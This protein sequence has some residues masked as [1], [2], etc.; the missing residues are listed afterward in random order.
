MDEHA[1]FSP[2]GLHLVLKCPGSIRLAEALALQGLDVKKEPSEAA[3]HGSL[4]HTYVPAGWKNPAVLKELELNDR[5]YV[6]ECIEYLQTLIKSLGHNN[7]HLRFEERVSLKHWGLSEVWGT[8][9]VILID[10]AARVLH[11]IDWKFGSGVPVYAYNNPQL[12]AYAGGALS[13]AYAKEIEVHVVQPPLDSATTERLSYFEL[14]EWVHGTLAIGIGKC[15]SEEPVFVP[16]EEQC[17]FCPVK[18]HCDTRFTWAQN[19]AE[20]LFKA[21]DLLPTKVTPDAIME[22]LKRAPLV[23]KVIKDL[24]IFIFNELQQGSD[25]YPDYKLVRG[26]SI[27]KWKNEADVLA[28]LD[29][30]DEDDIFITKLISPAQAEKLNKAFKKDEKFHELYEKPEGKLSLAPST[31]YREAV[32]PERKAVDIF[33]DYAV[34]DSLE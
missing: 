1:F 7:Y 24:R 33:A 10:N 4:S 15:L 34:P 5:S 9:D 25:L 27:R 3:A 20:K 11:V 23:E 19:H 32:Q 31:D 22:L 30:Y 28:F 16:G 17:R 13:I 14:Y 8:A 29:E 26:R 21:R 18:N 6:I 12:R 2:S